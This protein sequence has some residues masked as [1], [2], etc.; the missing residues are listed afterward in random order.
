VADKTCFECGEKGHIKP[1]CPLLKKKKGDKNGDND[2]TD[3]E[4]EKQ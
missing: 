1:K 3:K 4:T 2:E